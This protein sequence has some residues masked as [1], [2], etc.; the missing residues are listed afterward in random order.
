[1][2]TDEITEKKR[3]L[4]K[5]IL[6]IRESLSEKE[7]EKKSQIIIE[8]IAKLE[9][10]KLAKNV[11]IY[12][13]FKKE[14][15]ILK[16][17]DDRSKNFFFPVVDFEKKELLIRKYNGE[18]VKNKFGIYEPKETQH[19]E[20]PNIFEI[21]DFI[22]VPGIAFDKKGYRLGYGGGYYDKLLKKTKTLSCGVGYD[23]QILDCL[24][25]SK[26]DT[27]VDYVISETYFIKV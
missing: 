23:F 4:R 7:V 14:V 22:L 1:M 2:A 20:I 11:L 9:R 16:L 10:F 5:K 12:Y 6:E 13:P 24:P 21:I 8:N 26:F 15:N 3:I 25:V 17:M 18:F 19:S 27:Y